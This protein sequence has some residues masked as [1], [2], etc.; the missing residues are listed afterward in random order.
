MTGAYEQS[1]RF[2]AHSPRPKLRKRSQAKV[3]ARKGPESV[4]HV[5]EDRD[6]QKALVRGLNVRRI[7]ELAGVIDDA[8]WSPSGKGYVVSSAALADVAAMADY[9]HTPYRV[10]T[11]GGG[12]E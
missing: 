11:F 6:N 10:K 8:S 9:T 3:G 5:T 1:Q 2:L 7:L 4:L 12:E